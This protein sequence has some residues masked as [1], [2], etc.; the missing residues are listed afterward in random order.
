MHLAHMFGEQLFSFIV[1]FQ[2]PV[3]REDAVIRSKDPSILAGIDSLFF[4]E[5]VQSPLK[6]LQMLTTSLTR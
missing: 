5:P 4:D 1:T 3:L 2:Q 6:L